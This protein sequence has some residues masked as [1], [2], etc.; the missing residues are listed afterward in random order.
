MKCDY[1]TIYYNFN[2]LY[3]IL[4]GFQKLVKVVF[5]INIII[6][7]FKLRFSDNL[8]VRHWSEV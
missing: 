6:I 1:I 7:I 3:L 2:F 8:I 5:Q 4:R